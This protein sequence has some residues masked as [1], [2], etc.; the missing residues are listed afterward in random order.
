[1]IAVRIC[2][3]I[4]TQTMADRSSHLCSKAQNG[5]ITVTDH[6]RK[7]RNALYSRD[8]NRVATADSISQQA[9]CDEFF[10]GLH[11]VLPHFVRATMHYCQVRF[12]YAT[13]IQAVPSA[14]SRAVVC[15]RR[16]SSHS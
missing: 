15:G 11:H 6:I 10:S 13:P 12:P 4:Q 5:N 9:G 2:E 8:V 14:N 7:K 3:D 16:Q 1:M